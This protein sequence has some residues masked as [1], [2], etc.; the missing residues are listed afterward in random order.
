LRDT[1]PRYGTQPE[2]P[3]LSEHL[4]VQVL[5]VTGKTVL[6]APTF[7]WTYQVRPAIAV[8]ASPSNAVARAGL[9]TNFRGLSVSEM[10]NTA[11]FVCG[12]VPVTD[13]PA[14]F[15]PQPLHVG[16]AVL[17]IAQRD[18]RGNFYYAIVSPTQSISG[19]C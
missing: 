1:T 10:G 17:G 14:G 11:A 19:N 4:P 18:D 3:S 15:E 8:T 7:K 5:V 6:D 13:L 9:T 12:G 16:C 2:R